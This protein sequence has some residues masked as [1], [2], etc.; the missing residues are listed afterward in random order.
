MLF[1]LEVH[2]LVKCSS[3]ERPGAPCS[4][5]RAMSS[6][7]AG[8]DGVS[9]VPHVW[10]GNASSSLV[11]HVSLCYRGKRKS[12]K[13]PVRSCIERCCTTFPSIW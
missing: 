12:R 7:Q 11:S 9:D 13:P 5:C 10:A 6:P 1:I 2:I 4:Q 3:G 8:F